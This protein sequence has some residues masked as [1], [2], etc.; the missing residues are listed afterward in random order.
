MC[1]IWHHLLVWTQIAGMGEPSVA[2]GEQIRFC[3]MTFGPSW[4]QN[5]ATWWKR[6]FWWSSGRRL[7]FFRFSREKVGADSWDQDWMRPLHI[8]SR[9]NPL[10]VVP[11]SHIHTGKRGKKRRNARG[12]L[13]FCADWK[14]ASCAYRQCKSIWLESFDA[15]HQL[16]WKKRKLFQKAESFFC[17]S[18]SNHQACNFV[19]PIG[20]IWNTAAETGPYFSFPQPILW[21]Y[22]SKLTANYYYLSPHR[23]EALI[24]RASVVDRNAVSTLANEIQSLLLCRL[25]GSC[26]RREPFL[27]TCFTLKAITSL[28]RL[29]LKAR[30]CFMKRDRGEN[31]PT[32][33]RKGARRRL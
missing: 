28:N 24:Y 25:C 10:C 13:R 3:F 17:L 14:M 27:S 29:N 6:V 23:I 16:G 5:G 1:S 18:N 15:T 20:R 33:R 26:Q 30:G 32:N 12:R 4:I 7:P 22:F 19:S 21:S 11:S 9:T 8:H 2:A 31:K